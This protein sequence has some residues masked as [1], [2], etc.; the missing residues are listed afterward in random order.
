M[1][2]ALRSCGAVLL[3]KTNMTEFGLSP[4]GGNV[5]VSP[6]MPVLALPGMIQEWP[7][8][9]TKSC[10]LA[11]SLMQGGKDAASN[12]EGSMLFMAPAN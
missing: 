4:M 3:G 12:A 8:R 1:V 11:G 6:A 5:T 2:A 9:W 10:C 7:E